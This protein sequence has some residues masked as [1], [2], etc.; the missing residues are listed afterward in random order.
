MEEPFCKQLRGEVANFA[1]ITQ[2]HR[3]NLDRVV[4]M[5]EFAT[6]F[7]ASHDMVKCTPYYIE[8]TELT[9]VR[10]P[11][12]RCVPPKQQVFKRVVNDLLE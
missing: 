10:S 12:Y 1:T 11:P 4:S 8:L 5:D 6:L 2:T 7:T 9:L 3:N